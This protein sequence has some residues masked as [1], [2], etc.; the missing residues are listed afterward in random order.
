MWE[1]CKVCDEELEED[2]RWVRSHDN[3]YCT[4]CGKEV[5]DRWD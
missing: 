5:L 1:K 3:Y 4:E 2:G